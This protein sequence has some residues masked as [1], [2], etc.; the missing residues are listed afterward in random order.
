M[1]DNFLVC[2]NDGSGTRFNIRDLSKSCLDLTIV[3]AIIAV[4]CQWEILDHSTSGSNHYPI[5][6]TVGLE[7]Q[8]CVVTIQ[9]K[10]QGRVKEKDKAEIL[11]KTLQKAHSKEN[12]DGNYRR[13]R[14]E[15]LMQNQYIYIIKCHLRYWN[16]KELC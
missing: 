10:G 2:L 4:K 5:S 7:I 14:K 11:V 13:K 9:Q 1:K 8:R 15:M 3:S 6:C 12:L 16:L